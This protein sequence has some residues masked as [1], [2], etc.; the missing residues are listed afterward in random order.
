MSNA[1]EKVNVNYDSVMSKILRS[2]RKDEITN[3]KDLMLKNVN[4]TNA[5]SIGDNG[6]LVYRKV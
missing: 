1:M 6:V 4:D 2:G 5:A 3:A